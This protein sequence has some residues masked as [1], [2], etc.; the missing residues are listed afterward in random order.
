MNPT[1]IVKIVQIS[2]ASAVI[3]LILLML[4]LYPG[5]KKLYPFSENLI[6]NKRSHHPRWWRMLLLIVP[7]NITGEI[8]QCSQKEK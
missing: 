8:H 6:E 7:I 2:N 1:M 4:S 5:E 3:S